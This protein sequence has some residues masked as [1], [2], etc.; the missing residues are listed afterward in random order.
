MFWLQY[1]NN[2]QSTKPILKSLNTA[3]EKKRKLYN[4]MLFHT[5]LYMKMYSCLRFNGDSRT[6][7]NDGGKCRRVEDVCVKDGL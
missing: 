4:V 2:I 1:S 5:A 7:E 6:M 3:K